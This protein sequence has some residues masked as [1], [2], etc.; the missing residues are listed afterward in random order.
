ME[1][2]SSRGFLDQ[3]CQKKSKIKQHESKTPSIDAFH[4]FVIVVTSYIL[5]QK[6]LVRGP[7]IRSPHTFSRAH[8][9]R[10]ESSCATTKSIAKGLS[11]CFIRL[12]CGGGGG[13][14]RQC[15]APQVFFQVRSPQ[16]RNRTSIFLIR[17]RKS[18]TTFRDS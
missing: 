14:T 9:L 1:I 18:A 7:T 4:H 16:I 15:W 12:G 5:D 11:L 3:S 2:R 13:T 10:K 8:I 17:N 6:S